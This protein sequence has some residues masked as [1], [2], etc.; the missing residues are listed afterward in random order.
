MLAA[1]NP[2]LAGI[3]SKEEI[4]RLQKFLDEQNNLTYKQEV[5]ARS[6]AEIKRSKAK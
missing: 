1:L 2:D 6:C 3:Y 5:T 4:D